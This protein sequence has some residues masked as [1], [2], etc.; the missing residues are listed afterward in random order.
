MSI[1][2]NLL[3]VGMVSGK[4]KQFSIPVDWKFHKA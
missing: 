4:I 2:E 1:D 3:V